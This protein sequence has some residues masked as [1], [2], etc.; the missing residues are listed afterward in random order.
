M[1]D[2]YLE[3]KMEDYRR[4]VNSVSPRRSHVVASKGN[5]LL[6]EQLRVAIVISDVGLL[7]DILSE[8]QH[9][10]NLKSAF[11]CNDMNTGSRLAQSTGSLFVPCKNDAENNNY[12]FEIM[13]HRW[14]RTDV[15]LTDDL[16]FAQ[17]QTDVRV[18]LLLNEC[19]C[20]PMGN[21]RNLTTVWSPELYQDTVK[22][23]R[24]LP[25]LLHSRAS[26]IST[27]TVK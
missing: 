25:L 18:I 21:Q 11:V 14:G 17:L 8:F 26:I 24:L 2:N 5:G 4:G 19:S 15:I 9:H 27:V 3:K 10:D 12:L 7:N 23:A 22:L 16:D 20:H 13:A 6:T 1:A